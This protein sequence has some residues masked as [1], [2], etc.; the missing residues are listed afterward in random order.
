MD[1]SSRLT[2]APRSVLPAVI[3]PFIAAFAELY[4]LDPL[5]RDALVDASIDAAAQVA[6]S[7]G[8]V[9]IRALPSERAVFIAVSAPG[10]GAVPLPE[11][12]AR[13]VALRVEDDTIVLSAQRRPA[14]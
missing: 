6:M 2:L 12:R 11:P 9:T 10:A 3:A 13:I 7:G 8:T 5:V 14:A 1:L 4:D